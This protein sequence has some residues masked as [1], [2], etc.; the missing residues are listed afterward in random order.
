MQVLV[1]MLWLDR[2]QGRRD[3]YAEKLADMSSFG[4][5]LAAINAAHLAEIE[6]IGRVFNQAQAAINTAHVQEVTALVE[7]R[8][9]AR[10]SADMSRDMTEKATI[11]AE[12]ADARAEQAIQAHEAALREIEALERANAARLA[13]GRW[14]R[15]KAAWRGK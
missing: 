3:K 5:V 6:H 13:R 7:Q 4:E 14:E 10:Q 2:A 11:R 12:A 15:L 1:P 8:D 9:A